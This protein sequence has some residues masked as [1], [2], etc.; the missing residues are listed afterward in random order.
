MLC[1]IINSEI[2]VKNNLNLSCQETLEEFYIFSKQCQEIHF[3]TINLAHIVHIKDVISKLIDHKR[4]YP[5]MLIK[6]TFFPNMLIIKYGISK[7]INN[8]RCHIQ[9][10]EQV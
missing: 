5:T 7:H 4:C 6:Q 1:V 3:R 9:T 2:G 8:N 10:K